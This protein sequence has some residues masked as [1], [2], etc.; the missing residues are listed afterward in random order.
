MSEILRL[1]NINKYYGKFKAIDKLSFS[2]KEGEIIGYLGLNGSGKTTTIKILAGL[3]QD[4]Q[5]KIFYKGKKVNN[6]GNNPETTFIFDSQNFYD[7]LTA[8]E[9]LLIISLLN[10][11][12]KKKVIYDILE[13]IG[14]KDW[15][16]KPIKFFSRGM[17][18]RLA[19]SSAF[20]LN[21][22]FLI[23]DEPTNGLDI[24]GIYFCEKYFSKLANQGCTI[25]LSSHYLEEVERL[26]NHIII[27]HQGQKRFDGDKQSLSILKVIGVNYIFSTNFNQNIIDIFN[28]F[29]AE[30]NIKIESIQILENQIKILFCDDF[31]ENIE[32][33]N[34]F[35]KHKF[36]NL[37]F[38]EP[39]Q[40]HL[41]ELFFNKN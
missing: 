15:I 14:L 35:V 27:I 17:R 32:K 18:Q 20:L 33:T 2:I 40:R 23:L 37:L 30:N 34:D 26:A 12:A 39:V 1:E 16:N 11:K 38:I 6:I 8:Y 21:P 29:F 4:Y 25:L 7:N 13:E 36:D 5:G 41:K 3:L 19:L 9:N 24:D 28:N 31:I 22:S 10:K